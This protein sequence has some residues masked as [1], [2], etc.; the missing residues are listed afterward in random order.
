MKPSEFLGWYKYRDTRNITEQVFGEYSL[1]IVYILT[2]R[3]TTKEHCNEFKKEILETNTFDIGGMLS[4]KY[5]ESAKRM[6]Q[7]IGRTYGNWL[8]KQVHKLFF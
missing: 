5:R 1:G 6:A 4:K 8:N 3:E 2:K 7:D